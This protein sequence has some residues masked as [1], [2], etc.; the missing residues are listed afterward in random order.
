MLNRTCT[1][2]KASTS[3][4]TL[5]NDAT[6]RMYTYVHVLQG[7]PVGLVSQV[8]VQGHDVGQVF[9]QAPPTPTKRVSVVHPI[10]KQTVL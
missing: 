7:K 3:K 9:P 4:S 5:I 6:L 10:I 8:L 2:S 1:C